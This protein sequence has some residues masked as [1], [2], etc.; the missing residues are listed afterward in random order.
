VAV[1]DPRIWKDGV[2]FLLS[3]PLMLGVNKSAWADVDLWL[4]RFSLP[5]VAR[6]HSS[7]IR[8]LLGAP[9][10]RDVASAD[11]RW[12]VGS[13]NPSASLTARSGYLVAGTRRS[14]CHEQRSESKGLVR[15]REI[16]K[17]AQGAAFRGM[18]CQ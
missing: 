13:P 7:I 3:F 14:I 12:F 6:D 11:G 2:Y 5:A 4:P 18:V 9:N 8:S 15:R 1:G 17:I 10:T 16:G